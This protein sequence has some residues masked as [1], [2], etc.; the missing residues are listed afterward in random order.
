M[1]YVHK[2]EE[3]AAGPLDRDAEGRLYDTRVRS[4]MTGFTRD[5]DTLALEAAAAAR[6]AFHAVERLRTHG[7][8]GRG[9]SSGALDVLI[10]LN[11]AGEAG[12]AT[13]TDTA[14]TTGTTGMTSTSSAI[15]TAGLTVGELA[16]AGGVS[17]RNVTGLVDTLEREGLARRLPDPRDRRAV[18]V[19]ITPEG[20]AWL[21]AFRAPTERAMAAVFHGFSPDELAQLRHLCLRLVEN[22]QRIEQYLDRP[23]QPDRKP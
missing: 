3:P 10:R 16:R 6:S 19:A 11:A 7:T 8:Q 1:K 23:Q 14:D 2:S 13:P 20:R 18:L 17:S 21:E 9:L 5:G 12:A 22:Q 15:G 4:A